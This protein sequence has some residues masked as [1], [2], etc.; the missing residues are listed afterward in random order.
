[1][2]IFSKKNIQNYTIIIGKKY[3]WDTI[4]TLCISNGFEILLINE[5]DLLL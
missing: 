5:L 2:F 1:M 3:L 4:L